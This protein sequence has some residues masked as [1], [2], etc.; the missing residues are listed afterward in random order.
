MGSKTKKPTKEPET[1]DEILKRTKDL[2]FFEIYITKFNMENLLHCFLEMIQNQETKFY[3]K[4]FE[5]IYFVQKSSKYLNLKYT[6]QFH[7]SKQE[8]TSETL[9]LIRQEI[10]SI[11][12]YLF[13]R[14]KKK[15]LNFF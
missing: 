10:E 5:N 12:S 11:L 14:F 4:F 2:Q 6:E 13:Q 1:L 9:K 8:I 7:N 3:E 15:R